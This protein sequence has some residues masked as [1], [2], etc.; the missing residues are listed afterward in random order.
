MPWASADN[1]VRRC[2]ANR[3]ERWQH[4]YNGDP[5]GL[6]LCLVSAPN[7]TYAKF[8]NDTIWCDKIMDGLS[9]FI[10]CDRC[11]NASHAERLTRFFFVCVRSLVPAIVGGVDANKLTQ[12]L[13]SVMRNI[14]YNSGVAVCRLSRHLEAHSF[15]IF[16]AS[17]THY[18]SFTPRVVPISAH[19]RV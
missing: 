3:A 4:R 5:L 16:A 17:L 19:F 1:L 7:K 9:C 15:S 18:I 6:A 13:G 14:R 2:V 10:T 12:P 8:H 11:R